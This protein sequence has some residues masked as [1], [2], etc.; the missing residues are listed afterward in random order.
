MVKL[1]WKYSQSGTEKSFSKIG[2]APNEPS[3]ANIWDSFKALQHHM[4]QKRSAAVKR[5][6]FVTL[7]K[8]K[9]N[10]EQLNLAE[11]VFKF[12]PVKTLQRN[13]RPLDQKE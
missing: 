8:P 5:V 7:S 6:K 12:L 9:I 2:R 4:D 13:P 3:D 11:S 10:T 1:T